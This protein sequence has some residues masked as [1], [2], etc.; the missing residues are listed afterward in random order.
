MFAL[1]VRPAVFLG[2]G[3]RS[4]EVCCPALSLSSQRLQKDETGRSKYHR[5]GGYIRDKTHLVVCRDIV[6]PDRGKKNTLEL[7]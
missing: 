3:Q 6:G 5:G 2:A 4:W 7:D 1:F